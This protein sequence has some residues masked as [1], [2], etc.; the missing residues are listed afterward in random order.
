VVHAHGLGAT[1]VFT[2][3]LFTQVKQL[4][5]KSSQV[6]HR[7]GHDLHTPFLAAVMYS[8]ELQLQVLAAVLAVKVE[9]QLVQT[10]VLKSHC[11][12]FAGHAKQLF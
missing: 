10:P 1:D 4:P 7:A 3:R 2:A 5:V 6:G 9:L 8:P 12:Q 11:A